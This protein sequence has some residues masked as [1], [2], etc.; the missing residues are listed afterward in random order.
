MDGRVEQVREILHEAAETHDRVYRI[1]DGVDDDWPYWY[2]DWL[3]N[4]SEL[5]EALGT[6][7]LRSRLVYELVRLDAEYATADRSEPWEV[8]YARGL[9]DRLRPGRGPLA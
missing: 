5:P 3:V 8:F 7:P 4:L 9:V 1:T 2:A 6:E